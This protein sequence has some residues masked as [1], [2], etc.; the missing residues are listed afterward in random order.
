METLTYT[1][2]MTAERTKWGSRLA[3]L[4]NLVNIAPDKLIE[5]LYDCVTGYDAIMQ[6]TLGCIIAE[7]LPKT[8]TV[9]GFDDHVE[10]VWTDDVGNEVRG[11][12]ES[13]SAAFQDFAVKFFTHENG[14]KQTQITDLQTP[15]TGR[16]G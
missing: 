8:I 2:E 1:D 4:G 9:I 13:R 15:E 12:G 3:P 10:I 7:F 16:I 5:T 11:E 14:T 6:Y